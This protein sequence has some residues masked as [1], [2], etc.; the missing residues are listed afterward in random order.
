VATLLA[1]ATIPA[2]LYA[3]NLAWERPFK[4]MARLRSAWAVTDCWFKAQVRLGATSA[5]LYETAWFLFSGNTEMLEFPPVYLPPAGLQEN[6]QLDLVIYGM[7]ET[8]GVYTMPLDFLQLWPVDGGFRKYKQ[9]AYFASAGQ[10]IDT[11]FWGGAYWANFA[12]TQKRASVLA[13][14]P[15]LELLPGRTIIIA[16]ANL[17]NGT[18]WIIDDK[19]T[20]YL[21]M[22][23][24]R[25]NI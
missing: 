11:G 16:L 10:L 7:K 1:T 9:L 21:S 15:A 5:V 14:G 23:P 6:T 22:N 20:T 18:T 4:P 25:R 2:T 24:T 12:V 19:I 13:Y 8:A 17:T 3:N